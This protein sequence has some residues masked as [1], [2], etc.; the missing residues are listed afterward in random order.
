MTR[1]FGR[2][3]DFVLAHECAYERGHFGDRA[4]VISENASGD[5]GG[6][7]KWGIDQASH[8]DVNIRALDYDGAARIYAV[9]EWAKCRCDDLPEGVDIAVFDT[10]VNCGAGTAIILLQRALN[11]CGHG[12]V[13]AL[14]E[15]GYIGPKTI[16]AAQRIGAEVIEKIMALREGRYHNIVESN[17]SQRRFLHGWLNRVRDLSALCASNTEVSAI[18]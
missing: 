8:P 12:S 9:N 3:L 18:A 7:T 6:L 17:Q 1:N 13:P 16:R 4:H 10:A 5:R 15:D 11:N 2:A 14:R